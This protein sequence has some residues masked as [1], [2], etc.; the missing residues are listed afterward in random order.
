M[1]TV[2]LI[3]SFPSGNWV[4]DNVQQAISGADLVYDFMALGYGDVNGSNIPTGNKDQIEYALI[5]EDVQGVTVGETIEIPV[6]VSTGVELGAITVFMAYNTGLI[7]VEEIVS[8]AEGTLTNVADGRIALSWANNEGIRLAGDEVLFTVRATVLGDLNDAELFSL[9]PGT[10]FADLGANVRNDFS[11]KTDKLSTD[12]NVVG[13][14]L[15]QNYPNPFDDV[16]E[17]TYTLP[18]TGKVTLKVVDLH[19]VVVENLVS[20]TQDAGSYKVTFSNSELKAGVYIYV[21]EVEGASEDFRATKRM[22]I[23]K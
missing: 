12:V 4:F 6:R 18:E 5:Y 15:G 1:R 11:L 22:T 23:V 8:V 14:S 16:T 21:I 9:I 19:G 13:Y 2:N 3:T 7:S 10:E 20:A 17:I